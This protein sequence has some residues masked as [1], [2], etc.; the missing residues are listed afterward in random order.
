LPYLNATVPLNLKA[1]IVGFVTCYGIALTTA[2]IETYHAIF[3]P[4]YKLHL[5]KIVP[6]KPYFK[7]LGTF[8]YLFFQIYPLLIP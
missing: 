6:Y 4:K 8:I 1:L 5:E 2:L 3:V 7:L